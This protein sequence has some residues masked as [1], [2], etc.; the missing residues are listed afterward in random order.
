MK[1]HAG[2]RR[3]YYHP[4]TDNE[5]EALENLHDAAQDEDDL[6]TWFTLDGADCGFSEDA[7]D[8]ELV[9][10]LVV[11]NREETGAIPRTIEI[12]KDVMWGLAYAITAVS[13]WKAIMEL[14]K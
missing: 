9:S 1:V 4:E 11:S 14:V 3:V 12:L 13:L 2:E 6:L 5:R 8:T 10:A 7:T